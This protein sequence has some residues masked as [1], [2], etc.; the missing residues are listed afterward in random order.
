MPKRPSRECAR[1]RIASADMTDDDPRKKKKPDTEDVTWT[2]DT[3]IV[4]QTGDSDSDSDSDYNP[5]EEVGKLFK[6]QASVSDE[7]T[8]PPK[9][10][11]RP[12]KPE[13]PALPLSRKEAQQFK[14]L[15][16]AQQRVL[17]EKMKTVSKMLSTE[18]DVPYKFQVLRLPV[19]E[20]V[21]STILK[22][23]A[24]L[25]EMSAEMGESQKLKTWMDAFFRIPFGK[26]IPLPVQLS[27]GRVACS[28]FMRS[29]RKILDEAVYG[30]VP[31]KTQILQVLAQWVANPNSVGNVIAL[32][33]PMGVGKTSFARNG[34]AKVLRRPFEFF[35]LGGA[36]D[37]SNFVGHS[38]TQEGSM[39]GRIADSL[40]HA[41]CM[42]PVFYFDELDKVSTT[43]HGEEII[44]M[45][46]HLTDRSQNSQFHDRYFAGIDLD[47][48][49][50]LF[51]FSFNDISNVH[52]IL[53]DRMQVIHCSGYS[54]KDKK[55]I[56]QNF[57][58]P[59]IR[60]RLCFG[61]DEII[62]TEKASEFLISEQS[63]NEQGV[64][65][66]I[67]SVETLMTRLNMLRIADEDTMKEQK[68]FLKVE[69][70]FSLN[71]VVLRK[72]LDE[73]EKKE[74]EPWRSMYT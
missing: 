25:E 37:I 55:A 11:G 47:V 10:R 43:S 57:I 27:H 44:N 39:W 74:P 34:I 65:N 24:V 29:S 72:L 6:K 30:M 52:P 1:D 67:R 26:Q 18:N 49:Q 53:R 31:A 61:Q 63:G 69:F 40:M 21:Q 13:T 33:G 45:L 15:P 41:G 38:Y 5:E 35:S 7:E 2:P 54:E 70:P 64:R 16:I 32:Q 66:L 50:C 62:L 23:L 17:N 73:H 3:I 14:S 19:S 59:E 22:K 42:N 60:N 71:E 28:D 58:F 20:F 4:I 9:R 8:P 48:S 56:L 51:V 36:S 12:P 68:F 46:I